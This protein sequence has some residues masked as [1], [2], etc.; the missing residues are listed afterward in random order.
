MIYISHLLPD[1][2]MQ[3]VIAQ[4][5]AGVESI[6]FSISENLDSLSA[7][8]ASYKKRLAFMGADRLT[9]HGPFLDLNPMTY[10]S[11][12]ARVT[13]LR[14]AQAY[15]AARELGAEKI[16][17]H[18]GL[19][20]DA[21]LLIG[22]AERMADFFGEFLEDRRDI[23]VV[24]ENVFDRTWKPL[25]DMVQR[26]GKENFHLCLDVG[27]ANR[28]SEIPVREWCHNLKENMTHVHVHDNCGDRDAHL[29]VGEGKIPWDSIWDALRE[30]KEM[31]YT[32]ECSTKEAV[33]KSY[34]RIKKGIFQNLKNL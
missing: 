17:Y 29:A 15:E 2:E 25:K 6:E 12:I 18:S 5:G 26:V 33:L 9:L 34:A 30:R 1:E 24:V 21:Y 16:V 27:H 4:T 8:I 14:F 7:H 10:D 32:I 31:T 20:P 19:Y 11:G 13:K 23:D 3:E 28:Y 22:W